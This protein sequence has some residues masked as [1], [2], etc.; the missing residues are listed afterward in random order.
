MPHPFGIIGK[1]WHESLITSANNFATML[2]SHI[3]AP[4]GVGTYI[5]A[6]SQP[7]FEGGYLRNN[8][9]YARSEQRQALIAYQQ[10][11][12]LAAGD[13][14][15]ALIGYA[16]IIENGWNL[17]LMIRLLNRVRVSP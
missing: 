5:A 16:Q 1:S 12:Q 10:S 7:I 11:V 6:L 8:L 2:S 14:S 4:L 15:D 3:P 17:Q 13:V 9:R